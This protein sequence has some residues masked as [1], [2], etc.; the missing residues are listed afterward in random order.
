MKN[1]RFYIFLYFT[2]AMALDVVYRAL[3]RV[4]WNEPAEWRQR[5]LEQ[6]TG[7]YL[8]ML[9]LP[10]LFRFVRRW[11]FRLTLARTGTHALGAVAYS[12]IHTSLMW[13]TRSILSPLV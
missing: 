4:V 2:A 7:Y 11:P 12:V 10:V 8:S 3:D 6:G 9:L 5:I 13:G 1:V